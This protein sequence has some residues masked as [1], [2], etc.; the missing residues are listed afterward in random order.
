MP[1]GIIPEGEQSPISENNPKSFSTWTEGEIIKFVDPF[2]FDNF[3]LVGPEQGS[4][5][6]YV[7]VRLPETAEPMARG[8]IKSHQHLVEAV[9][10]PLEGGSRETISRF[11]GDSANTVDASE[12]QEAEWIQMFGEFTDV[13]GMMAGKPDPA[14][15][16]L[17]T[18]SR[19]LAHDVVAR[20]LGMLMQ[21]ANASSWD[22]FMDQQ[23]EKYKTPEDLPKEAE[24][25]I[26][27][28]YQ[29]YQKIGELFKGSPETGRPPR[30]VLLSTQGK[31]MFRSTSDLPHS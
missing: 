11:I 14:F 1:G 2:S 22:H 26:I 7:K 31:E 29:D 5:K 16:L 21:V 20:E 24:E 4:E 9:E 17:K 18:Q 3:E 19:Q 15:E 10:T 23:R 28:Q 13:A 30:F 12:V 8:L 27:V 6:G 25:A